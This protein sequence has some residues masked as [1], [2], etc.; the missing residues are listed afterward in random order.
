MD[1][2]EDWSY[3]KF[4]RRA[5]IRNLA[6][7]IGGEPLLRAQQDTFRNHSRI[8]KMDELV[9]TF[10]FE[11]VAHAKLTEDAYQNT[12]LGAEGEFTLRRNRQVFDWVELVPRA[13]ADVAKV[14]TATEV[15][16]TKL[17]YPIMVAPTATQ[18]LL[19]PEGEMAMHQGA[20]AASNTPMLISFNASFPVDKIAAAAAGPLWYQL[21][22]R[23]TTEENREIVER[24][25]EAGCKAIVITV[26]APV[27]ELRERAL[28]LRNLAAPRV[29]SGRGRRQSQPDPNQ[30][31]GALTRQRPWIDWKLLDSFRSAIKVPLVCKAIL[32]A[33]DALECIQHGWDGIIVSNHGARSNDCVPSTLEV[34]PEIVDAVR[35]RLTVMVD[36]GFRR[37]S[38]VLKALALGAKAVCLGRAPRYGLAAYG[39]AGAQRVLEIVQGE[40]MLAMAANGQPTLDSIDRSMVRTDFS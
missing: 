4:T 24:V 31:Y 13:V 28:H 37:G 39:P 21:Y 5:K 33:E 32:T 30:K 26:D 22:P 36:S 1:S 9:T 40:L 35:G 18:A 14:E 23:Q 25:Q 8:P 10:D 6:M 11:A 15:L 27:G 17:A 16:G 12:A 2:L 29:P 20:T 7:L 34:L 3:L 19:H 38:D